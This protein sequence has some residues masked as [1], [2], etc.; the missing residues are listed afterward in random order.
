M[1][2]SLPIRDSSDK[3]VAGSRSGTADEP[4]YIKIGAGS[5]S[6][7]WRCIPPDGAKVLEYCRLGYVQEGARSDCG[8]CA[9]PLLAPHQQML[10]VYYIDQA[11]D[12]DVEIYKLLTWR[13]QQYLLGTPGLRFLMVARTAPAARLSPIWTLFTS[14]GLDTRSSVHFLTVGQQATR[15]GTSH[16]IGPGNTVTTLPAT[17]VSRKL[18]ANTIAASCTPKRTCRT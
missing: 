13:R 17:R 5:A 11:F 2:I 18:P 14:T 6:D 12:L 1:K 8:L 9:V 7:I 16:V 10:H 15:N 3:R 4:S